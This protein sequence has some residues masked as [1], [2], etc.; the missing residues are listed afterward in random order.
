MNIQN[1]I[2]CDIILPIM[3]VH[4]YTEI[5]VPIQTMEHRL[6]KESLIKDDIL[7]FR[8]T[9]GNNFIFIHA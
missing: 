9:I 1:L 8:V 5:T 6:P 4:C 7:Q 2:I 3:F